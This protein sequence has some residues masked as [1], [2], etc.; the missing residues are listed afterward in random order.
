MKK[1]AK[2]RKAAKTANIPLYEIAAALGIS[3]STMQR[4]LRFPMSHAQEAEMLKVIR[5]LKKAG[6]TPDE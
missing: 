3:E 5:R 1:N 4:R 6:A 2:I